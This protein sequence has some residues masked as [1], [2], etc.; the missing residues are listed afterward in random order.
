MTGFFGTRRGQSLVEF[1]LVFPVLIL[2]IFGTLDLG[3]SIFYYVNANGAASEGA[4][5]AVRQSDVLPSDATILAAVQQQS[6]NVVMA[7]SVECPHGPINNA[8]LPPLNTGWLYITK[9]SA[10][11]TM[12]APGGQPA[13]SAAGSCDAV[14]PAS[15]SAGLTITIRY[16][17]V[18]VTPLISQ[19][20]ANHILLKAVVTVHTEY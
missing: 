15:G 1:A 6:P 10:G 8:D 17:F 3:R 16:N 18:P 9:A 12:N 13:A 2:F 5:V 7:P 11:A 4:R 20:A 14:V 19:V